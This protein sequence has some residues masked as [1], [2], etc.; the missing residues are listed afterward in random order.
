MPKMKSGFSLPADYQ[1]RIKR[2]GQIKSV[3]E[4]T[5]WAMFGCA[6]D[7]FSIMMACRYGKSDVARSIGV[8]GLELGICG[9]VVAVHPSPDLAA[10]FVE[11]ERLLSW[12]YRW[13]PVGPGGDQKH[14]HLKA[15]NAFSMN[16]G[17]WLGS[18]HIQALLKSDRQR[19]LCS[20]VEHIVGLTGKPPLFIFDET[21]SYTKSNRW[22]EIPRMLMSVG[23]GRIKCPVVVCTATPFRHDEDDIWG[24]EKKLVDPQPTIKTL[25]YVL[26]NPEDSKTLILHTSHREE[27]QFEIVASVEV[28][29]AQAWGEKVICLVSNVPIDCECK[30]LGVDEGKDQKLS[31][32]S[33]S[34]SRKILG[35]FVRHPD[36][37]RE[38]VRKLLHHLAEHQTKSGVR[39]PSCVVYGMCDQAGETNAHLNQIQAEIKRQD[40]SKRCMIATLKDQGDDDPSDTIRDFCKPV[41]YK[42]DILLLKQMGSAGL[43]SDR[44]CVVVLLHSTRSCVQIV[45]QAMRGGNV[46]GR[47]E[48]FSVIH[49]ADKAMARLW[50][51]FLEANGG[52]YREVTETAHETEVIIPKDSETGGYI[53]SGLLDADVGDN[54]GETI[55]AEQMRKVRAYLRVWPE[56]INENSYVM[57]YSKIKNWQ[58]DPEE[59][60]MPVMQDSG[61]QCDIA[62]D[63]LNRLV[64]DIARETFCKEHRRRWKYPDDSDAMGHCKA[65]AIKRIKKFAG[66]L[67]SWDASKK[68]ASEKMD[69]YTKWLKAAREILSEVTEHVSAS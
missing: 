67:D 31:E 32:M 43:D 7:A 6:G 26:P 54:S 10:Q 41:G 24:F 59:E 15:W 51:E 64:L 57:I 50:G 20:Y 35:D 49:P 29:F 19:F 53:V 39:D 61:Y 44:I 47:K 14:V 5:K 63:D 65:K 4:F 68:N 1:D 38:T 33:E 46:A 9:S 40:K 42:G 12:Q 16:D 11:S 37:I 3:I 13:R 58:L 48:H 69:D 52:M 56:A 34:D 55:T 18:V 21:Q 36:V 2:P 23:R 30:G 22:G 27:R 17:E 62:R 25:R 60:S 8:K 45:Q 28:P 66:V